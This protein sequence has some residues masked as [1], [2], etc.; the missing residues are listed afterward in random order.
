L[1]AREFRRR[2]GLVLA[3]LQAGSLRA[4]RPW[5][6]ARGVRRIR[7][8][9]TV[10]RAV[11]LLIIV[12][13]THHTGCGWRPEDETCPLPAPSN[14]EQTMSFHTLAPAGAVAGTPSSCPSWRKPAFERREPLATVRRILV[15]VDGS[16]RSFRALSHLIHSVGSDAIEVHVVNVQRLVMQGDFALDVAVRLEARARLAAAEQ[17]LQRARTLLESSGIPFRTTVL[18]GDPATAIAGHAAEHRCDAIVMATRGTTASSWMPRSSVASKVVGLTDVPV[19]LVKAAR[20][21][22]TQPPKER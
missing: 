20:A 18:F 19:T 2:A 5:P 10:V 11:G 12:P 9:N 14:E 4:G 8:G 3:S 22:L 21:R 16:G 6:R 17:V 1:S 15:P 7:G 13:A